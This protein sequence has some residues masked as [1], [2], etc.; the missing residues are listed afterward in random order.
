MGMDPK[1]LASILSTSAC[2]R[3][4]RGGLD[5]AGNIVARTHEWN[6]S[7][8]RK[9]LRRNP[10]HDGNLGTLSTPIQWRAFP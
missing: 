4:D 9:A 10:A 5:R 2:H 8:E 1:R 7:S 3:I 6:A